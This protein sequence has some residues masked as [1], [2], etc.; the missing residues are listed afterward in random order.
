MGAI[1]KLI[2]TTAKNMTEKITVNAGIPMKAKSLPMSGI[3]AIRKYTSAA[4]ATTIG[5]IASI[6]PEIIKR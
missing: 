2:K 3:F 6:I 4:A 5:I 1:I